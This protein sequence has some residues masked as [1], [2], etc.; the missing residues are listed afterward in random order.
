[1][2]SYSMNLRDTPVK[3]T[4]STPPR[5]KTRHPLL[6]I[7]LRDVHSQSALKLSAN[8]EKEIRFIL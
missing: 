2:V 6:P 5:R 7:K 1:M 3:S 4:K 8:I